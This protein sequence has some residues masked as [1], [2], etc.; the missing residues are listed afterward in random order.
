MSNPVYDDVY[1]LQPLPNAARR[2]D[3]R[4]QQQL[5]GVVEEEASLGGSCME[6]FLW[7]LSLVLC[8]I[9]FPFSLFV[10][11]K[12]VQVILVS[13]LLLA[14]TIEKLSTVCLFCFRK[15]SWG[16]LQW[17]SGASFTKKKMPQNSLKSAFKQCYFLLFKPLNH[18][19][20]NQCI[21]LR[22]KF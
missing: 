10:V 19:S 17:G 9:T 20:S 1:P 14:L 5:A 11:I 8:C 13:C 12:Q 4:V 2:Q 6:T 16:K 18:L 7:A 22:K 15:M 3:T 21:L